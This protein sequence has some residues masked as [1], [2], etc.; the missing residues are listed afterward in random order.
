ESLRH[1]T[2]RRGVM[3]VAGGRGALVRGTGIG[4]LNRRACGN[5]LRSYFSFLQVLINV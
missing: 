1:T 2:L 4:L 5:A 3:Q